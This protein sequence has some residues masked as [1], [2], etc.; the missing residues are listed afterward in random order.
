MTASLIVQHIRDRRGSPLC[1]V[2]NL[3][4]L[5]AERRPEQL[6]ALARQLVCAA[7]DAQSGA[8]GE[9]Q[10]PE[11]AATAIR[12]LTTPGYLEYPDPPI[13]DESASFDPAPFRDRL[14]IR[15]GRGGIDELSIPAYPV[16][17][18]SEGGSHD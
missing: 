11:P 6:E 7:R 10:Y 14:P 15:P 16:G 3:P 18:D 4:G 1:I 5:D 13:F 2:R 8:A 12:H 9:R 17:I